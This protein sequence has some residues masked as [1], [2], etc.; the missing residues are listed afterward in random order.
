MLRPVC[1]LAA[2]IGRQITLFGRIRQ[3]GG[4]GAKFAV[5][6]F[7]FTNADN[8]TVVAWSSYGRGYDGHETQVYR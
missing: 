8:F 2:T 3:D 1:Q 6:D 5:F 4:T 7:I